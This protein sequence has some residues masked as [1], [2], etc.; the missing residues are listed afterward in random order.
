MIQYPDNADLGFDPL[1]RVRRRERS[2]QARVFIHS[3]QQPEIPGKVNRLFG[4]VLAFPSFP[5]L[6]ISNHDSCPTDFNAARTVPT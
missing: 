2:E 1:Q 6:H 3:L 5:E 4:Y